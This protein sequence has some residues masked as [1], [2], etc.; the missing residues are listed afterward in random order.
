MIL[1]IAD[2]FIGTFSGAAMASFIYVVI[3]PGLNMF[4]AM[5]LGAMIGMGMM[6]VMMLLLMPFFGAFEV[7]IPLHLNAMFVGMSSGMI[8]TLP[9]VTLNQ[10][11]MGGAIV[12]LIVALFIYFSNET[13]TQA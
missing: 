4:L 11:A 10:L 3:E 6:L 2:F 13:L 7:M 8:S 9:S 5:V 12:G 1:K